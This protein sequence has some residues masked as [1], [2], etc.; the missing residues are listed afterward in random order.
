[1]AGGRAARRGRGEATN[2]GSDERAADQS[3]LKA[4]SPST[5]VATSPFRPWQ[6]ASGLLAALLLLASILLSRLGRRTGSV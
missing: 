5:T 6:I 1:V 4:G 3:R 2:A